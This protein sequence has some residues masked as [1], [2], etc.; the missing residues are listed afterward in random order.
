LYASTNGPSWTTGDN[1]L[2]DSI[3][4]NRYGITVNEGQVV[5]INLSNNNLSG[6]ADLSGLTN[7]ISLDLSRNYLTTLNISGLNISRGGIAYNYF[8]NTYINENESFFNTHSISYSPQR[9]DTNGDFSITGQLYNSRPIYSGTL[10][11]IQ[12]NIGYFGNYASEGKL[13]MTTPIG[14]EIIDL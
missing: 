1:W 6:T 12:N 5:A 7:L 9:L 8:S 4:D 11:I 2:S 13:T 3:I 10:I 14:F